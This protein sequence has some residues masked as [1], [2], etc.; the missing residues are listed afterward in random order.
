[1]LRVCIARYASDH[2]VGV[3][4]TAVFDGFGL[5]EIDGVLGQRAKVRFV[6][7]VK[8]GRCVGYIAESDNEDKN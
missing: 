7:E 3:I 5:V 8:E 2:R 1:M 4:E 6:D